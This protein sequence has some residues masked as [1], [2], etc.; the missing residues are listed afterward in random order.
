MTSHH[1]RIART[2][3]LAESWSIPTPTPRCDPRR[4]PRRGLPSLPRKEEV[5]DPDRIGLASQPPLASAVLGV[6]HRLLLPRVH[7]N[8]RLV[9]ALV[10]DHLCT[11]VPELGVPV[12]A[13][14]P[15]AG[16]RVQ[17]EAVAGGV[18]PVR[19]H[20]GTDAVP[21]GLQL[22]GQAT[23]APQGPPHRGLGTARGGGFDEGPEIRDQPM[24]LPGGG[25]SPPAGLSNA[26]GLQSL[27]GPD[28]LETS[29]NRTAREAGGPG[30]EPDLS[31]A[32]GERLR[33]RPGSSRPLGEFRAKE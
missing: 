19:D 21:K 32:E 1:R 15:L 8:H 23:G 7:R 24:V 17:L 13:G 25:R 18:E 3:K 33:R 30:D 9:T 4:T 26:P 28:L 27:S 10:A 5:V 2:A 14:G 11:Q 12:R 31:V 16:L 29:G 22:S 20:M 6:P